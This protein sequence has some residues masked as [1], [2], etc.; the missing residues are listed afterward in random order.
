MRQGS[1]HRSVCHA[2]HTFWSQLFRPRPPFSLRHLSPP[3]H[4]FFQPVHC[5]FRE[6]QS[7]LHYRSPACPPI[8]TLRG[9]I[10]YLISQHLR[11]S[12]G[13]ISSRRHLCMFDVLNA[14]QF[15]Q[16]QE[17]CFM[18]AKYTMIYYYI[19]NEMQW[20]NFF[21]YLQQ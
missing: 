10:C 11:N 9:A 19:H 13:K 7:S 14:P 6:R 3:L 4:T 2:P 15:A 12:V 17:N 21:I 20:S 5:L 18:D 8:V 16:G 1:P